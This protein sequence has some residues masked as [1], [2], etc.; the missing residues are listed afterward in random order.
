VRGYCEQGNKSQNFV[1]RSWLVRAE[2][3]T[4]WKGGSVAVMAGTL[5]GNMSYREVTIEI[6]ISL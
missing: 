4:K 2:R 3:F 1:Q 6:F 5:L